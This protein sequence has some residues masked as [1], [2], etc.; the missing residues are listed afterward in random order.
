Y[1]INR[2]S[3]QLADGAEFITPIDIIRSLRDGLKTNPK[4]GASDVEKLETLLTFVIEEY[5]KLARNDVQ[6]AFFVNF[7]S[8]IV[9]LLENY[10][11]NVEAY[12]DGHEV[13]DEW[14]ESHAPD[15]KL[16]RSIE[17]KIQITESGKRSFRQEILRK[18]HKSMRDTGEYNY[19]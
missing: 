9:N 2:I 12:L 15:E 5:N 11:D 16:M 7:E 14:G 13:E 3:A 18:M 4:I 8:E 19:K 17:E 1:V 6:K 10:M